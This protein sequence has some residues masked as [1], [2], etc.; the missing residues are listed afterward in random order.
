MLLA[1]LKC[2]LATD[3]ELAIFLLTLFALPRGREGIL[4]PR[5][6]YLLHP[7]SRLP[8]LRG[9]GGAMPPRTGVGG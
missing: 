9:G 6:A 1:L 2:W 7:C 3:P 4:R 5:S 8:R